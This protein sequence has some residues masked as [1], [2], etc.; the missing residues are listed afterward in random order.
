MKQLTITALISILVLSCQD[1]IPQIS[2]TGTLTFGPIEVTDVSNETLSRAIDAD[3]IVE[4]CQNG[5][6]VEYKGQTFRFTDGIFPS[7]LYLQVGTYQVRAFNSAYTEVS[8]WTNSDLG[9]AIYFKEE[10]IEISGDK[11]T[12]IAMQVPMTN[13]GV[14]FTLPEG[15]DQSFSAYSFSVATTGAGETARTVSVNSPQTIYMDAAAFSVTLEATNRDNESVSTSLTKEEVT[16]G[17]LYT[18]TYQ[19]ATAN[20]TTAEK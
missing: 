11:V 20:L 1:E 13:I 6:V 15:F 5:Q 19:V 4:I 7:T 14:T 12:N 2:Q 16:A 17:T 3:L 8:S 18:V 9:G 10:N